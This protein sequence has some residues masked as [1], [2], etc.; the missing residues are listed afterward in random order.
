MF[1]EER[2]RERKKMSIE[3]GEEIDGEEYYEKKKHQLQEYKWKIY[4]VY[5]EKKRG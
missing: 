1:T 4:A 2:T 3:H 5:Y